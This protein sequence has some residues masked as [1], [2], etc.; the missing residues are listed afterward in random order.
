MIETFGWYKD[1][2]L[3]INKI[4]IAAN[5]RGLKFAD[6]I[7]ETILIKENKP[8]LFDEHLKRLE[9]SSKILNI[10]LKINKL[11]LRQLIHDGIR[12]LSLK[13]DQFASVRINFSRGT[14]E[15]RTLTIDSTSKTKDLDNLWLE[16]F[17]IKPNFN[18]IRVCISQTEKINENLLFT[19]INIIDQDNKYLIV[20]SKIPIVDF[21]FKL[22]DLNSRST[23]FIL[24][25]IEKPGDDLIYALI[26]KNLSDRQISIDQKLIE[27]IIKRIDRTYG[28]ISDFIYK[29]DEI[30]LKRK[31]PIDF[32]II[33]EALEV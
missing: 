27:F 18:P 2:W 25:Q 9:K 1:Q 31:K 16:F 30:S 29:I 24:S 15:G 3:D 4:F 7:F 33:K 5:N 12:K 17:K 22:N 13:N 21:K 8:I 26:L 19:L 28:K 20:T 14:N 23:N 6:G 32:K 11:T 10:N